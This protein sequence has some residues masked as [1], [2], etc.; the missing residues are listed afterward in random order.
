MSAVVSGPERVVTPT[1]VEEV[2]DA[3]AAAVADG[4]AVRPVGGGTDPGCTPADRPYVALSTAG[5]AEVEDYEPADLTVTAGAGVVL[6]GLARTLA[7][8]GQWLP[9]DPPHVDRRTLG[10]LVA[11]GASGPL[12][13]AYGTPRDHVLGLTLVTGDGRVL[14]LGGR[15]MKNVAG[16]DLVKL[17]VGSRGTLGVVTSAS[18]RLFPWPE[19]DRVLVVRG[20]NPA[21]L[22]APARAVAT[23]SVVPASAVLVA[24]AS[25]EAR[26]LVR[27]QGARATVDADEARLMA[28]LSTVADRAT[29]HEAP[30]LVKLAADHAATGPLVVRV[31]AWPAS[32]GAALSAVHDALPGA[33]LAADVISGRVRASTG[34]AGDVSAEAL[35]ELRRR[36]EALGG[37]LVLERAPAE[38]VTQVGAYGSNG[39]AAAFMR[40]LRHRF[41]PEG[42]FLAGG[43]A[44]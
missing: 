7:D 9:A 10:G 8:Q 4:L 32:L 42:L 2:R 43:F 36:A 27:L 17:A 18:V 1:S 12:G 29:D 11:T 15:V 41:D 6:G 37:G 26:L 16:F 39:R 3:L 40:E 38:L 30:G 33:A 22:L 5:L 24:E 13:V 19:V 44:R 20:A 14:R 21:A 34:H 28:G 35:S 25:G 23:S 31:K